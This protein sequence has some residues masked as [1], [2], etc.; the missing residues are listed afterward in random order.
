MKRVIVILAALCFSISC[1]Q[2][3][4]DS[5]PFPAFHEHEGLFDTLKLEDLVPVVQTYIKSQFVAGEKIHAV[6]REINY[7]YMLLVEVI[8]SEG[9]IMEYY[10]EEEPIIREFGE[11]TDSKHKKQLAFVETRPSTTL[12]DRLYNKPKNDQTTN[13]F[14]KTTTK[15]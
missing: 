4:V 14:V 10:Y 5:T 12:R 15:F 3:N 9:N 11:K 2:V 8:D 1:K 6:L 7:P 13:E